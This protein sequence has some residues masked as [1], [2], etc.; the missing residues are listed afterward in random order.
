MEV[1][2]AQE[3]GIVNNCP[4]AV[5]KGSEGE[6]MRTRSARS[7]EAAELM[8]RPKAPQLRRRAPSVWALRC[9]GITTGQAWQPKLD[10]AGAE[11][12]RDPNALVT[13][14]HAVHFGRFCPLP[15]IRILGA[16]ACHSVSPDPARPRS[17]TAVGKGQRDYRHDTADEFIW[18][19]AFAGTCHGQRSLPCCE[20]RARPD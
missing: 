4:L 14:R 9:V 16:S 15:D 10:T 3:A 8:R 11:I 17:C 20:Q 6:T 13:P 19:Q 2:S 12:G 18:A 5:Q 7:R 1:F